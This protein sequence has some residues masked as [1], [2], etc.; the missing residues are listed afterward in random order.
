MSDAAG[1][2]IQSKCL[3]GSCDD[4][5]LKSP[6][7]GRN[8]SD[9]VSGILLVEA[10]QQRR[11]AGRARL[12]AGLI[13]IQPGGNFLTPR[14][15]ILSERLTASVIVRADATGRNGVFRRTAT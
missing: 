9:G 12:A 8:A 15:G 10:E 2:S 13:A 4:S 11:V 6:R 1:E 5:L 3:V 7:V 14:S